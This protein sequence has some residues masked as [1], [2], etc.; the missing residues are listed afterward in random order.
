MNVLLIVS[1]CLAVGIIS[2]GVI[3][4]HDGN[5]QIDKNNQSIKQI[6]EKESCAELKSDIDFLAKMNEGLWIKQYD[7]S[8]VQKYYK[9]KNCQ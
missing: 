2:F 5:I 8:D 7:D 3:T 1:I 9:E 6:R 4:F